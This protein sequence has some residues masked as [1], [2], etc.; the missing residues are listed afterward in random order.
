MKRTSYLILLLA[1]ILSACSTVPLTNRKQFLLVSDQE[2]L[3]LGLQSYNEYIATAQPSPDSVSAKIVEQCGVKIQKAVEE[4][5]AGAG[6]SSQISG[7]EWEF[8]L[9]HDSTANAFCMPGGKV[10]VYD[11]LLPYTQN[12]DELA[13]V[14]G[15]RKSTRL[16]SSHC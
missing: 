15:D 1:V 10:V 14:I 8:V 9:T 4:Y 11:G 3:A 16:N 13:V 2:V 6:L 5:L 12:E 7:Y